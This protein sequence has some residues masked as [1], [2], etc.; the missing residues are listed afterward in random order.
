MRLHDDKTSST[1]I[2]FTPMPPPLPL[3]PETHCILYAV[4]VCLKN[5]MKRN[6]PPRKKYLLPIT[7]LILSSDTTI[8]LC[9]SV[10]CMEKTL[11]FTLFVWHSASLFNFPLLCLSFRQS[12]CQSISQSVRPSVSLSVGPSVKNWNK[13]N[14]LTVMISYVKGVQ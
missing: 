7:R 11:Q 3:F 10:S 13:K 14:K 2:I 1:S 9:P 8:L 12:V 5:H 6:F 4:I